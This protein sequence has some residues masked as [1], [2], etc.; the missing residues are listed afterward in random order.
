MYYILCLLICFLYIY[1]YI[2]IYIY[3]YV[4]VYL[5][6]FDII[7]VY[8]YIVVCF[9]IHAYWM[10]CQFCAKWM[11]YRPSQSNLL[12]IIQS[13]QS[14]GKEQFWL[15]SYCKHDGA[16]ILLNFVLGGV[17]KYIWSYISLPM[18]HVFFVLGAYR[19]STFFIAR[20]SGYIAL[21]KRQL[22]FQ[23]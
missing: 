1:I 14:N 6:W 19:C 22:V 23:G 21:P 2:F 10:Y 3:I 15:D 11:S 5:F 8:M 20:D 16:S 17:H 12:Y 9:S 7:D 13:T 18:L 4:C